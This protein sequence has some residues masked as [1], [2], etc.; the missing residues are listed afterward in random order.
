MIENIIE[1]SIFSR[2]RF[3]Y[4]T[5]N[6][7]AYLMQKM[8]LTYGARLRLAMEHAG[9]TQNELAER[10]GMKQPSVAYLLDQNK[11]ATGSQ[12]TPRFA[13][14]MGVSVDWLADEIGEMLPTE[15]TT[16]DPKLIAVC[17]ALEPRAEYVKDA[18]VTAVLS[19]CELAERAKA[20]GKAG[21][22]SA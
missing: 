17:K 20:N 7:T 21:G 4:L 2:N 22:E 10:V 1:H 6:S 12:Y 11:N 8:K 14:V 16:S 3:F 19:T 9:L 5:K 15:F 13:R 18:A